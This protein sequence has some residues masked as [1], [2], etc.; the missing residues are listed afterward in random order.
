MVI[1]YNAD[2]SDKDTNKAPLGVVVVDDHHLVRRGIRMLLTREADIEVIAEAEDGRE[3]VELVEQLE[4]DVVVIDVEMPNLDGI[5]ATRQIQQVAPH[6]K[7]VVVSLYGGAS[8]V[9]MAMNSGA[10]GYVLK[11][12]MF[13]DL[14]P[15]V[16]AALA[17]RIFF[18]SSITASHSM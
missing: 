11:A 2:D 16:R 14:L 13:A 3:A 7:T 1:T 17:G 12:D 15:A 9:E 5:A 6:T 4:P 18:S 8:L 10:C